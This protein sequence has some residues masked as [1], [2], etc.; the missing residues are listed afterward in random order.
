VHLA[1]K[2]NQFTHGRLYE[3]GVINGF[4]G[5]VGVILEDG[6]DTSSTV[7]VDEEAEERWMQQFGEDDGPDPVE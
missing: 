7:S 1:L 5:P 6:S 3:L 2:I 4:I